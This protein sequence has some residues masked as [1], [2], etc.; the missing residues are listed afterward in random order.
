MNGTEP[1]TL[2]IYHDFIHNQI[3]CRFTVMSI[4]LTPIDTGLATPYYYTLYQ[5]N[6]ITKT[7]IE[8]YINYYM[9]HKNPVPYGFEASKYSTTE[10]VMKQI[11]ISDFSDMDKILK[12]ATDNVAK[13]KND[14]INQ[15]KMFDILEQTNYK[16]KIEDFREQIA[17]LNKMRNDFK[18]KTIESIQKMSNLQ[19]DF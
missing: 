5:Y 4:D 14:I 16:Q 3:K 11:I 13:Q 7:E 1:R 9:T 17:Q 15:A 19:G 8:Q 2:Y 18:E 6:Q 10:K 12:L